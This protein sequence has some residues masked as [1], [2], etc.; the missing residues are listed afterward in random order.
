[1]R[2]IDRNSLQDICNSSIFTLSLAFYTWCP[3]Q[4][5]FRQYQ[6]YVLTGKAVRSS[7]IAL[8]RVSINVFSLKGLVRESTESCEI[9]DLLG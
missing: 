2:L 6:L 8:S 7:S 1:M 9:R 4:L 3:G 5:K